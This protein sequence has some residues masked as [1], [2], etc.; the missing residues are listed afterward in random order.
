[1][2]DIIQDGIIEWSTEV[3]ILLDACRQLVEYYGTEEEVASFK[4]AVKAPLWFID[5]LRQFAAGTELDAT[6]A[7]SFSTFSCSENVA[8]MVTPLLRI[9][10]EWQPNFIS[11]ARHSLDEQ[12]RKQVTLPYGQFL[13]ITG[14][15]VCDPLWTI[16]PDL[17]PAG[18]PT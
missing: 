16:Y 3:C 7:P 2:K 11:D 4:E 12:A 6:K 18:W 5:T 9:A 1:M 13:A 8:T 17:T 15:Y 10:V 14:K